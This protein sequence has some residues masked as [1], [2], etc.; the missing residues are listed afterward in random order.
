M[1][2]SVRGDRSVDPGLIELAN[3]RFATAL[4]RFTARIHSTVIRL[5]DV[6]GPKGGADKRCVVQVRLVSPR[7]TAIIEDTGV[8]TAVAISS[9]ADRAARTVA[10]LVA[11]HR[12]RH[13]LAVR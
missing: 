2:I 3:L 5:G 8:S 11:T 1:K 12:D 4:G 7:R 13:W 10:R 6:N 9:A